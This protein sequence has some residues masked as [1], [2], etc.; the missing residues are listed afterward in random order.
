MAE[1][2]G[3]PETLEIA[4]T[5]GVDYAQGFHIGHPGPLDP[6]AAAPLERSAA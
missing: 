4:R 6:D 2:V 1:Y 5:L 3:D